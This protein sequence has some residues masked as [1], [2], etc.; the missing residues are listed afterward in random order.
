[1]IPNGP[2]AAVVFLSLALRC[3]FAPLNVA[4]IEGEVNFEFEDL[5]EGPWWS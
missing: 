2:E 3:T 4:L 5:P 1:M